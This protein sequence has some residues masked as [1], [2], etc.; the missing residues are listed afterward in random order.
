[1]HSLTFSF[2]PAPG[3]RT[4]IRKANEFGFRTQTPARKN[5]GCEPDGGK[6]RARLPAKPMISV[7]G[8]EPQTERMVVGEP[9]GR[10]VRAHLPAKPMISVSEREPQTGRSG[11]CAPDDGKVCARLPAKPMISV[12]ERE[13]RPERNGKSE[14]QKDTRCCRIIPQQRV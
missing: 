14:E 9:D 11:K 8:R 5:G 3:L 10:K 2:F 4:A 6:V 7:S 12:S 1:M 13:P